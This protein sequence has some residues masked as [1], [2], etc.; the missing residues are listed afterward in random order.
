MTLGSIGAAAIL[1]MSLILGIGGR[2]DVA[3][4]IGNVGVIVLLGTPVAGLVTTW[5]ELRA[6]RPTHALLAVA[7]LGV[8]GLATL[9]AL[10]PRA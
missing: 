6:L 2:A 10:I 7:V 8:L 3:G 5:L 1:G 9:I 4:L